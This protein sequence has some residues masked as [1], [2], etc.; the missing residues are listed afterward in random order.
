MNVDFPVTCFY[1]LWLLIE[2]HE[3]WQAL[4][5]KKLLRPFD[6]SKS[7]TPHSWWETSLSDGI[8][9]SMLEG[10]RSISKSNR[11]SLHWQQF[12][13]RKFHLKWHEM[14]FSKKKEQSIMPDFLPVWH[15]PDQISPVPDMRPWCWGCS[16]VFHPAEPA[17]LHAPPSTFAKQ[18]WREKCNS[19][20]FNKYCY[21]CSPTPSQTL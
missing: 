2:E 19:E 10:N 13:Q 9:V 1:W 5:G 21:A 8:C 15:P 6:L 11:R 7:A 18:R 14:V 20:T 17:W 4:G 16:H 12:S 3:V